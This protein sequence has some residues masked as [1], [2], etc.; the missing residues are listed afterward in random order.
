MPNP[1]YEIQVHA[2]VPLEIE[3]R[4]T[5]ALRGADGIKV[6]FLNDQKHGYSVLLS[7][8]LAEML[9]TQLHATAAG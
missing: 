2:T 3:V 1:D 8:E 9:A 7:L 6:K 5:D 4:D